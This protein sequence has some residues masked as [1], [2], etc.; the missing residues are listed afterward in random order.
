M[1]IQIDNWNKY[2]TNNVNYFPI[3]NSFFV[4]KKNRKKILKDIV[5][6]SKNNI[7]S[8]YNRKKVWFNIPDE[9]IVE[10][11]C[12]NNIDYEIITTFSEI[13]KRY[14]IFFYSDY[15]LNMNLVKKILYDLKLPKRSDYMFICFKKPDIKEYK[16]FV[17]WKTNIK[18]YEMSNLIFKYDE[19]DKKIQK[20]IK[21]LTK[22][23]TLEGFRFLISKLY[24]IKKPIFCL[25][26]KNKIRGLIGPVNIFKDADKNKIVSSFYFGVTKNYRRKGYGKILFK[27]FINF[28]YLNNIKYFLVTNKKDSLASLFYKKM[29]AKLG[30]TYYKVSR[31][32]LL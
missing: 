3:I 16:E 29:G 15:K 11:Y 27:Y 5:K 30:N 13:Y 4:S 10:K 20:T 14:N 24:T 26:L 19:L 1:N 2:I 32:D 7:F 8:K 28:C 23:E 22:D 21:E 18:K 25:V 17:I 6:S 9:K 12:V 31:L